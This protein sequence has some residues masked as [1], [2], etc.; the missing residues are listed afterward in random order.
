MLREVPLFEALHDGTA[1]TPLCVVVAAAT[2]DGTARAVR[3]LHRLEL[4]GF[5]SEELHL[6]LVRDGRG[7]MPTAARARIRLLSSVVAGVD[8]LP[9]VQ[10]WRYESG[11]SRTPSRRYDRAVEQFASHL[12][13]RSATTPQFSATDRRFL[14]ETS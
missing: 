9:H 12:A 10:R 13:E 2:A 4:S 8:V 14:E 5:D 3:T 6:I 7:P 1:N 11:D